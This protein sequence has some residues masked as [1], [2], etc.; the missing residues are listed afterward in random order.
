ML[1]TK[2]SLEEVSLPSGSAVVLRLVVMVV[3]VVMVKMTMN[4]TMKNSQ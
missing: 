3:M 4:A 1:P 2:A